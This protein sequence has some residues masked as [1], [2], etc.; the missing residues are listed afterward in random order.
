MK[1]LSLCKRTH[2][3]SLIVFVLFIIGFALAAD[4]VPVESPPVFTEQDLERYKKPSDRSVKTD[5]PESNAP[6]LNIQSPSFTG[7]NEK[8][9]LKRYE[10]PYTPLEGSARRIIIPVTFN[11]SVTARMALDTGSPGMLIS[12]RLAYKLGLFE[13]DA[14]RLLTLA[15]G[16]GGVTPAIITVIDTVQVAGA[17]D[18]FIPTVITKSLSGAFEGLIGM[19]FMANYS[20]TIDTRRHVVVFNELPSKPNMPAGHDEFWWRTNFRDFASMRAAWKAY[21]EELDRQKTDLKNLKELKAFA[22]RQYK[23]A[24]KLFE[25]LNGYAI[26]NSVPM[27]WR[28][29]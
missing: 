4:K 18:Q 12:D 25:K 6:V 28:E 27:Q 8:Q 16:I 17:T 11:G 23:E 24:D 10:L 19:D 26:R 14:C 13:Q 9:G 20:I 3:F 22:D 5:K 21:R 1:H 29:Y 2:K 15:A 7:S